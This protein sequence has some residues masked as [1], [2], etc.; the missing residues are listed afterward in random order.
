MRNA[1]AEVGRIIGDG[2]EE[3]GMVDESVRRVSYAVIPK[4]TRRLVKS[5]LEELK[6]KLEEHFQVPLTGYQGPQ[7]LVYGPETFYKAHRD[8]RPG[9]PPDILQRRVSVVI[10]LNAPGQNPAEEDYGGGGALTFYGLL[11]GPVW[12]RCSFSLES[13][14]GLL[15]AFRAGVLHEVKPVISG[16]RFAIVAWFTNDPASKS[17]GVEQPHT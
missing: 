4:Q 11:E 12:E 15:V 13:A 6:P 17:S 10:F 16:H 3:A 1:P 7:F 5:H 8:T 2:S 14:T 9:A